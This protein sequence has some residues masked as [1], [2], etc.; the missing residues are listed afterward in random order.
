MDGVEELSWMMD[1]FANRQHKS[2]QLTPKSA[3]R[4]TLHYRMVRATR[5]LDHSAIQLPMSARR[6]DSRQISAIS[7]M[8]SLS[9]LTTNRC[10]S[11]SIPEHL[12]FKATIPMNILLY[13]LLRTGSLSKSL[14]RQ[15]LLSIPKWKDCQWK[16]NNRFHRGLFPILSILK[17]QVC[18][19]CRLS[20]QLISFI[21]QI[22][23]WW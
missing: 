20:F 3:T 4:W 10:L 6:T 7:G 2:W 14:I 13:H 21:I 5:V 12:Y 18:A 19:A 17:S 1:T 16:P 11:F 22:Q 9:S 15:P 8:K 23:G